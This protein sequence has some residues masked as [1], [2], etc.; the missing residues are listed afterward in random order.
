MLIFLGN[1]VLHTDKGNTQ[2]YIHRPTVKRARYQPG[3]HVIT[4]HLVTAGHWLTSVLLQ[5][6]TSHYFDTFWNTPQLF[7]HHACIPVWKYQQNS[8]KNQERSIYCIW[9]LNWQITIYRC[10]C[11]GV[12]AA[13]AVLSLRN[14]FTCIAGV[15]LERYRD[16]N[17]FRSPLISPRAKPQPSLFKAHSYMPPTVHSCSPYKG[18][19]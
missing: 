16:W 11:L 17:V 2:A 14:T 12:L 9:Q 3:Q 5:S 7:A 6:W 18:I 8:A 13:L 4:E 15:G 19:F 10:P 1:G